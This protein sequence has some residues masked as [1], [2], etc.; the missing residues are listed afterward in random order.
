MYVN[1]YACI[2][3]CFYIYI[4]TYLL[5]EIVSIIKLDEKMKI[6]F[7]KRIEN[8]CNLYILL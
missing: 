7:W 3:A 2:S 8:Q 5:K 4:Y 1:L 6:I